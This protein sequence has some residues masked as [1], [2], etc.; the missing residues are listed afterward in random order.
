M[1][2]FIFLIFFLNSAFN[3]FSAEDE[4]VELTVYNQN[5]ALVKDKRSFDFKKGINSLSFRDVASLIEPTSVHFG[6]LTS[7]GSCIILEQ[8]YEYDLVN[9]SKLLS[10]YIDKKISLL[11]EDGRSYEGTLLSHDA[12]ALIISTD[13]GLRM[14][15]RPDNIQQIF[16]DQL[17]EGFITKP[18]LL[19]QI[20]CQ[21]RGR[22]LSE[23]SYLTKGVNWNC[24]YV[25]VLD[26]EDREISLDG[27]VS[28]TNNSGTAYKEA[29]LKLIA[30]DVKRARDKE[31]RGVVMAEASLKRRASEPQ[32]QEKAFFEY[33]IY[34]LGRETTLK[35][36]QIK[37][38]SLLNAFG[39]PIQKDF[40]FDLSRGQYGYRYYNTTETLKGKVRVELVFD[41]SKKNNLGMPLPKGKVKVYKKDDDDSLQFIGEDAI[42]HTP[43]DEE[44]RLYIGD[45]FDVT[46]ERTRKDFKEAYQTITEKYE[47]LLK[48]HKENEVAV[49]VFEKLWRY[50]N[51]KIIDSTHE[52]V[53]ND[54]STI[55]FE[56]KLPKDAKEKLIYTVRYWW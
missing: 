2:K 43:K 4:G 51:W 50:S 23:V 45:A 53:K 34:S 27:W 13:E 49:K 33:H 24:E 14:I 29:K 1:K 42:D 44:I 56:V 22:H 39:V 38:S 8:N 11:S 55:E 48:N 10:K 28:I 37:Q 47:I 7:P 41:N 36:N 35:N 12:S 26:K 15:S 54:A 16:F 30:G 18:T 46:G 40:I 31:Y 9:T 25:A 5:F 19:W 20:D 6:S 3:I 32:F 21:K 52:W 17:P